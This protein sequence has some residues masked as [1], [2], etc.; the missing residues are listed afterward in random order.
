MEKELHYLS[1]TEKKII[2]SFV[3]ELKE[4]LG[5]EVLSVR[6]FSSKLRGDFRKD[7]D[8]DI[9][10]LVREKTPDIRE[11]AND[12]AANYVFD[13]DIPLSI[14]LCDLSEYRGNKECCC[15]FLVGG[16]DKK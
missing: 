14:V 8:I 3:R 1:K 15:K 7:S 5:D 9:Y 10:I 4:K 2:S 16:V 13:Y 12:L 11:K 6:L